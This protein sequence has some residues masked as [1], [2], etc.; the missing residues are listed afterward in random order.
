[1][2][3]LT[4]GFY[5]GWIIVLGALVIR[6]V[7]SGLMNSFGV[8]LLPLQ[9]TFSTSRGAVSLAAAINFLVFAISQPA[10][11]VL[12]DK[13]G[14]KKTLL[15]GILLTGLSHILLSTSNS[16]NDIYLYYGLIAGL[17][18]CASYIVPSSV[19]VTNWFTQ[20]RATALSWTYAG[21]GAGYLVIIP[22]TT[23]LLLSTGWRATYLYLGI[24]QT[25]VLIPLVLW[26]IHERPQAQP[27]RG[28]SEPYERPLNVNQAAKTSTFWLLA[29]GFFACGFT[30]AMVDVH[31]V[32]LARSLNLETQVAAGALGMVGAPLMVGVLLYGPLC[33]RLGRKKPLALAYLVRGFALL[34]ILSAR[35]AMTLYVY[36]AIFGF[37]YQATVPPTALLT[38]ETFGAKSM[39]AI[40]GLIYFSHQMGSAAA[41]Y[42]GGAIF[43]ATKSYMY[44][45]LLAAI[46]SIAAA[47]ASYLIKEKRLPLTKRL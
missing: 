25:V 42:L 2:V 10:I 3:S 1:M 45:Y 18:F 17:G 5:Y 13:A 11:G 19:L 41:S 39:G 34:G 37:T 24:L 23:F 40:F 46:L 6:L 33:D 15:I 4:K 28:S 20:K 31:L 21:H 22:I 44:A 35:D 12:V 16:L 43:D 26:I 7:T 47:V 8:L 36:T 30:V 29:F 38:R 27:S 32:P 14:A 9:S